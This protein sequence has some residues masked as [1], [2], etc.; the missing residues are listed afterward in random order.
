[1]HS[2]GR[3]GTV[4]ADDRGGR[5][6]PGTRDAITAMG[7]AVALCVAG[8]P[9]PASANAIL[10]INHELIDAYRTPLLH[11]TPPP[12]A[13]DI[14]FVGIAMYDAVNAATGMTYKPYSYTGG[15]VA[16]IQADAAAYSAGYT[17]LTKLFPTMAAT[18]QAELQTKLDGLGLPPTV[19]SASAA[20]GTT[21]ATDYMATRANDGRATA[22]VPYPDGTLPGEY[23]RTPGVVAAVVPHWGLVTPF[24]M[25]SVSQFTVAKPPAI[26]SR[27]WIAAYNEVM[28]QGCLMC[29]R[30]ADQDQL[31]RFWSDIAGT[32]LPPGHWLTILDE[33]AAAR[34]LS[35]LESARLTALLGSAVADASIK[36]WDVK[37]LEGDL[38]WRPY[39]AITECT[40]AT[41]GVAGDPSWTSLWASPPFPGYISGHSTFSASAATVLADYFGDDTPFC[42][43]ADP[44]AGFASPVTRCFTSFSQ[45]AAEAGESRILGGIHF[46]F[47]NVPGLALGRE[48]GNY[49]FANAFTPVP[50]PGSMMLLGTAAAALGLM[51]GL[52]RRAHCGSVGEGGVSRA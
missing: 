11:V 33:L 24:V 50:E 18:Y 14:G 16:G 26:G 46:A 51:L 48:I 13:A 10:D 3:G 12:S 5:R 7:V 19:R 42:S 35:T 44:K 40:I 41:C 30:T 49:D 25:T 28:T 6:G 39:T 43:T 36:S 21:I 2:Q 52:R 31:S 37:Y 23:Q 9:A 4:E 15:P 22:Q 17:V 20:L 47:D 27:E 32:Q 29:A 1:M 8:W 34:G 45:A 38:A